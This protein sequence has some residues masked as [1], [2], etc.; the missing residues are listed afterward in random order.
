MTVNNSQLIVLNTAENDLAKFFI[1]T[2]IAANKIYHR[3]GISRLD[4]IKSAPK[5]DKTVVFQ[6]ISLTIVHIIDVISSKNEKDSNS[7]I[8]E[9]KNFISNSISHIAF[10]AEARKRYLAEIITTMMKIK[11]QKEVAVAL[12]YLWV[13]GF[14]YSNCQLSNSDMVKMCRLAMK[15][16]HLFGPYCRN[17]ETLGNMLDDGLIHSLANAVV[18]NICCHLSLPKRLMNFKSLLYVIRTAIINKSKNSLSFIKLLK[19]ITISLYH[20]NYENRDILN[21]ALRQLKKA[22]SVVPEIHLYEVIVQADDFGDNYNHEKFKAFSM[23]SDI[24]VKL[25]LSYKPNKND[26]YYYSLKNLLNERTKRAQ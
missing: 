21:V 22:W 4:S 16:Y 15:N 19:A 2:A 11:V 18:A 24:G 14:N 3:K 20:H 8:N 10:S 23:L 17:Y 9:L 26:F 25:S 5:L 7:L 12:F 13:D 6:L 1:S